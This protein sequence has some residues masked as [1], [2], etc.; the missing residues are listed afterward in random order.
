MGWARVEAGLGKR[1]IRAARL[2]QSL[3]LGVAIACQ[4]TFS[5]PV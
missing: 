2:V 3:E 4:P 1:I 5:M